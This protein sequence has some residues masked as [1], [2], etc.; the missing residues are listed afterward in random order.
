M[1]SS[2]DIYCPFQSS[3]AKWRV[4]LSTLTLFPPPVFKLVCV[5]H[6]TVLHII[7]Y[8]P[9]KQ[10]PGCIFILS[11]SAECW[12]CNLNLVWFT[13]WNEKWHAGV[14]FENLSMLVF[15]YICYLKFSYM[16]KMH[17]D[18]CH[19]DPFVVSLTHPS[20][21]SFPNKSLFRIHGCSFCLE[22]QRVKL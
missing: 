1:Y 4:C 22:I 13:V 7:H 3:Y 5:E 20:T 18:D 21:F 15:Y 2:Y 11:H 19:P 10:Y 16:F 8:P 6:C 12:L 14:G 17:S 9:P